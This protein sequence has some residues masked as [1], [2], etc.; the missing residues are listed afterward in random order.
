MAKKDE[1][2]ALLNEQEL[3]VKQDAVE[4][5]DDGK[6]KNKNKELSLVERKVRHGIF[7]TTMV[8]VVIAIVVALNLFLSS[9]D[10]KYDFTAEKL[11]TLSD[12]TEKLTS[13]LEKDQKISIYFLNAESS[14]NTV[15]KNIL[16]QYEKLSKN[17]TV[18]YKDMELYPNFAADYLSEGQSA[19][20]ND[21]IVV[22]GDRYRY[23]SSSD[24]LSY[25]Y[26]TGD[27]TV[28]IETR[29]TSAI[30]YCISEEVVKVYV[31]TGQ[32]E[33]ALS[34]NFETGLTNDNYEV[35]ELDIVSTGGI[36]TDCNLLI[37]NAPTA[38]LSGSIIENIEE[39]MENDGKL[40]VVLDPTKMYTN[41]NGLLAKYGVKVEEGVVIDP[42]AGYYMSNYP[43]YLLP[44]IAS[45]DI[46]TPISNANLH[47][48]APVS[49]GLSSIS[50]VEE[51]TATDLLVT[52]AE[53]YSKIDTSSSDATKTEE[54]IEGP[55]AIAKIVTDSEG[56]GV[57]FVSGSSS[58][59]E[60]DIDDYVAN[61]NSNFYCNAVNFMA[62]AENKISVKAPTVTQSYAVFSAFASKMIMAIGIIGIPLLLIVLGIVVMVV[63][64]NN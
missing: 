63:R 40:F 11:Y 9:K 22:C 64:R 53:S 2:N 36:P 37:I 35:E 29:V 60:N 39:Y 12:A 62:E 14:V 49:K 13:S 56:K 18:E 17:I 43:T 15:Y 61:A 50:D 6:G 30:D 4:Q 44:T 54:D 25:D 48:V 5:T 16:S 26:N 46:S 42:A 8:I 7:S 24:Y 3:E 57:V 32:G 34:S 31:M 41:L 21:M 38:D 27:T 58:M 59:A 19:A 33:Q 45:H 1:K 20:E 10:W 52:S 55:L 51:Y 28:N 47:I 23:I